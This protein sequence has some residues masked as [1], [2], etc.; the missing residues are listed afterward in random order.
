M[1]GRFEYFSVDGIVCFELIIFLIEKHH[2]LFWLILVDLKSHWNL[3][4]AEIFDCFFNDP[5]SFFS[6]F[7][8]D[9]YFVKFM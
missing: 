6:F 3:L 4:S 2:T 9:N 8:F 1:F 7:N 5:S